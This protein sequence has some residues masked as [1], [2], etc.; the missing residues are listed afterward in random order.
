MTQQEIASVLR[1]HKA[2]LDN[3]PDGVNADLQGADLRGANLCEVDMDYAVWPLWCGSLGVVVDKR[4]FAQ[5]AY[6]L[7]R[8]QVD[9]PECIAAQN[10]LVD[11]ANQCHRVGDCGRVERKEAPPC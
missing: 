8:V 11:I 3:D 10:D 9:D 1:K 4:I 5:L 6:H 7:C 2:W